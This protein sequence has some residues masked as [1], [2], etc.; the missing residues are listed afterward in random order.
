MARTNSTEGVS[1]NQANQ[2]NA[3]VK[4][5]AVGKSTQSPFLRFV[6]SGTDRIYYSM[7]ITIA[8]TQTNAN[9]WHR[10][11]LFALGWQ[12]SPTYSITELWNNSWGIGNT[13]NIGQNSVN[14][15]TNE[16]WMWNGTSNSIPANISMIAHIH[17]NRWDRVTVTPL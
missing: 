15:T 9:D 5:F 14:S 3:Y 10:G 16:M 17:C 2:A 12:W 1:M 8:F 11:A 6:H 4:V 13:I 7:K